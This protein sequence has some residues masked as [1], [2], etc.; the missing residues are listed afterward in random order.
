MSLRRFLGVY[1]AY[2]FLFDF[3]L[4]YAIYTALFELDGLSLTQIGGL[5]AFWS[6]SAIVLELPSGALSDRFD[7]RWLLIAAPLA[8]S[9]TFVC[10]ALANGNVW[11]YGLGFLF[12][13]LGQALMS[14]TGEALV[15]ERLEAD[16]LADDYDKV[17]GR[18]SA[19]ESLGIGAGTLLGGF[20]A[21]A[22]GM[23]STVWLALP[24]LLLCALLA[25]WLR[26]SRRGP[27]AED[28]GDEPS[29][30]DNFRIAFAEFRALPDMRF[31]TLYIAVG[32]ILFEVLQEFDQLYYL[33][34]GLPLWLFGVVGASVLGAFAAAS[35]LAHR[36]ARHTALAWALPLLG[37]LLLL[38]ASFADQAIYVLVLELAYLVVIPASILA[39]ARFQRLMEGRSRATT[40]SA[41]VVA[42]NV[43]G[44]LITLGF[45]ILAEWVGILPAYGW[46]GVAMLPVALWVWLAQRSG[47]RA[48]H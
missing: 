48:L 41:L 12:W 13:S 36:L 42:Q 6:F 32:L 27:D 10:W 43:T 33:A 37:G 46:A 39:E 40:T 18:A 17:N 3:I 30:F 11:L 29:Y 5:L 16:G 7:R 19:A 47:V 22:Y 21:A 23:V 26:D 1:Y 31:V 2:L 45:G 4:C 28:N 20:V 8:K 15:Y 24:P 44:I 14:G 35:M 25:I 38:A 34:V 9:L